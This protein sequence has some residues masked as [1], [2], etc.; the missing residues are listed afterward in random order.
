MTRQQDNK[1]NP[2][3]IIT[4]MKA[5]LVNRRY[6]VYITTIVYITGV[7][8]LFSSVSPF[9]FL[10]LWFTLLLYFHWDLHTIIIFL[11]LAY[12]AHLSL[13]TLHRLLFVAS[14]SSF[15]A[16]F[17]S[18]RPQPPPRPPGE[19]R[20]RGGE[21]TRIALSLVIAAAQ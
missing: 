8:T 19:L 7:C 1:I 18:L 10:C 9:K 4:Q 17:L 3:E 21:W 15:I 16:C 12:T 5:L 2:P 20:G 14:F 13:S 6:V 11:C